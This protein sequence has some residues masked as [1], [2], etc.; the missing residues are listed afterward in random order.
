M[1]SSYENQGMYYEKSR[2]AKNPILPRIIIDHLGSVRVV[3]TETGNV[4]SWSDY[5]PFGKEARSGSSG[6]K[7]KEQFTG[8]ESDSETTLDYFGARYFNADIVR[9]LS[10]DPL[11]EKHPDWNPYNYVLGN[12]MV[13]IDPDGKQVDVNDPGYYQAGITTKEAGFAIRNPGIAKEIGSFSETGKNISSD[14][15]RFTINSR[16]D[17]KGGMGTQGNAFRHGMWQ[18]MIT[19]DFGTD[20]ASQVGNAHESNP[21]ALSD[22][23]NPSGAVFSGENALEQADQTVDLLNNEIGKQIGS[24]NP[25]ATNVQLATKVLDTFRKEGMWT[26]SKQSDGSYKI[27]KTK[28]A[29]SQYVSALKN[30]KKLGESG[31]SKKKEKEIREEEK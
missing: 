12:P 29:S 6:N 8:K 10:V 28:L 4:D 24:D 25:N 7:P 11:K 5:Y 22:L 30:V 9:W 31:F 27:A 16:L 19:R 23:E 14:A 21:F 18:A 1:L 2:R 13:L 15:G 20:I 17:N 26:T 3:L